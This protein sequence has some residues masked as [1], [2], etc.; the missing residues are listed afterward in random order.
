MTARRTGSNWKSSVNPGRFK[1]RRIADDEV[2]SPA[3]AHDVRELEVKVHKASLPRDVHRCRQPGRS[4]NQLFDVD[5][6]EQVFPFQDRG[7]LLGGE[8]LARGSPPRDHHGLKK[9]GLGRARGEIRRRRDAAAHTSFQDESE[10]CDEG[11]ARRKQCG[12]VD[13]PNPKRAPG[14]HGR[15]QPL[16]GNRVVEPVAMKRGEAFD[17]FGE[18]NVLLNLGRLSKTV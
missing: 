9:G 13:G 5:V 1:P 2:K 10:V 11:R 8:Q 4:R 7:A 15:P 16:P 6:A 12:F 18:V 17:L 3:F 14:V